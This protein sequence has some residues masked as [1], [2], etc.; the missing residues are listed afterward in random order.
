MSGSV[1]LD[2]LLDD[3]LNW[4]APATHDLPD[5]EIDAFREQLS[6]LTKP[7]YSTD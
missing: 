6:K 2:M 5:F 4:P 7:C 3:D 1:I